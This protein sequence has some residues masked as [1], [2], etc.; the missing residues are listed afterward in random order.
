MALKLL[1][2][3]AVSV[4]LVVMLAE[5]RRVVRRLETAHLADW[6]GKWLNRLDGLN[7]LW[8]RHFHRLNRSEMLNLPAS[9]P[10]I[11][12][13]NHVS[14]LDPLLLVAAS[15]RPLRFLIAQEEYDRRWLR[16]LFRAIGGIPVKRD[17]N[18][19]A[20][21]AA[22]RHALES[23]N[24][25]A[26]FPHGRIHL[27]YEPRSRLKRGV[28]YLAQATGAPIIPVRVEGIR[29]QGQTVSAIFMRSRVKLKH[30]PP[31]HFRGGD[32]DDFLR[33]L[34]LMLAGE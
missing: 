33:R 11:V 34:E 19:R 6:G 15:N 16:G 26:L 29:G 7:R 22:A 3:A 13:A 31:L 30:F 24:V 18:P 2:G 14:G 10:A 32:A 8:C 23:G 9:G 5:W 12:V 28:V 21:L 4:W 20:A 27:D 1:L 17:R 25:V